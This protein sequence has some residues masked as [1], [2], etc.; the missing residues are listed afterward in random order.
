MSFII[1]LQTS[2]LLKYL[3]EKQTSQTEPLQ[4]ARLK[5]KKMPLCNFRSY[6][7]EG[8]L[9]DY[10]SRNIILKNLFEKIQAGF[11]SFV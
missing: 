9:C 11:S 8:F 6:F 4:N 5:L 10:I 2:A 3:A 1:F 7:P